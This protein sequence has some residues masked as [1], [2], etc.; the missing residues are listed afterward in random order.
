M[1]F[2]QKACHVMGPYLTWMF[3]VQMFVRDDVAFLSESRHGSDRASARGPYVVQ[4]RGIVFLPLKM[5]CGWRWVV[6]LV[7]RPPFPREGTVDSHW[8]G[9]WMDLRFALALTALTVFLPS[10][11]GRPWEGH[12]RVLVT[13][14]AFSRRLSW[15]LTWCRLELLTV[16]L[17]CVKLSLL[18]TTHWGH[19]GRGI[20]GWCGRPGQQSRRDGKMKKTLNEK[21]LLSSANSKWLGKI[22]GS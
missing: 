4:S 15:P 8:G 21:G 22:K 20:A 2:G 7:L 6:G 1:P 13:C 5:D 19:V 18:G 3:Q 9:S 11:L 17:R 10:R 14:P 12:G 16:V